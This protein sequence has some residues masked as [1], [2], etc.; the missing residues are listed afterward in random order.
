MSLV[1]Q[2]Q[3]LLCYACAGSQFQLC[4]M[5]RGSSV[6]YR[7]RRPLSL[8]TLED[9]L[10]IVLLAMQCYWIMK[11]QLE[12]LPAVLL[13][14][15]RIELTTFSKVQFFDNFVQKRITFSSETWP[16][17]RCKLMQDIYAAS[18]DCPFLIHA[19]EP[20]HASPNGQEYV[21]DLQPVGQPVLSKCSDHRPR[22]SR[23]L[24]HSIRC[25]TSL[26]M[27]GS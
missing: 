7:F 9:R 17:S 22:S 23:D 27:T 16:Q 15:G 14:L 24:K 8:V 6:A 1:L 25:V 18:K 3:Y 10:Q 20:P 5:Q 11:A 2:V 12:Q 4:A 13:P 19:Q 26:A 21:V